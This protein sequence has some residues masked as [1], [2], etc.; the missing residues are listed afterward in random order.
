MSTLSQFMGGGGGGTAINEGVYLG[1][2][3]PE[4]ILGTRKYL[5][6]GVL[7][8]GASYPKAATRTV[9]LDAT[10]STLPAAAYW[11]SVTYGGGLLRLSCWCW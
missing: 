5:R 6:S 10:Q 4:V 11:A 3:D 1:F 8:L 9:L 7:A 2:E